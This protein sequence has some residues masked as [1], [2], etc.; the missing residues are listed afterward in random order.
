MTIKVTKK[1]ITSNYKGN[2]TTNKGFI[3]KVKNDPKQN[4]IDGEYAYFPFYCSD[5][6]CDCTNIMI[7]ANRVDKLRTAAS[8][9]HMTVFDAKMFFDVW[10][11]KNINKWKYEKQQKDDCSNH[12]AQQLLKLLQILVRQNE[13][14]KKYLIKK[15]KK[16]RKLMG[17]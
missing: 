2:I 12:T 17:Y 5:P 15:Y 16:R 1:Y 10:I 7:E 14:F 9:N 4:L 3:V 6:L 8:N 13:D 11:N